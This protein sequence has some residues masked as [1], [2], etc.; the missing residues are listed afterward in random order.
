MQRYTYSKRLLFYLTG[1]PNK[2]GELHICLHIMLSLIYFIQ[3]VNTK[4]HSSSWEKACTTILEIIILLYLQ[5]KDMIYLQ[6]ATTKQGSI[7]P[8]NQCRWRSI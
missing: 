5:K 4:P 8:L 7:T 6:V 2:L 1:G 3:T